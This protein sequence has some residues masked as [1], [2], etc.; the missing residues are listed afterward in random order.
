MFFLQ[1]ILTEIKVL[2]E[3]YNNPVLRSLQV[4]DWCRYTIFKLLVTNHLESK[5]KAKKNF[6]TNCL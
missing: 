4:D 5:S 1:V 3:K 2:N 6:P